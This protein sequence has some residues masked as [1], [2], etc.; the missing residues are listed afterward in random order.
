MVEDKIQVSCGN[1]AEVPDIAEGLRGSGKSL[2]IPK[3][4]AFERLLASGN[5]WRRGN[6]RKRLAEST[7]HNVRLQ[8]G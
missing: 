6:L 1:P 8:L 3:D 2:R 4:A 7:P 5:P